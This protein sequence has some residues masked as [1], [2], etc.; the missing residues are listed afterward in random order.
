M[1]QQ[2]LFRSRL[3]TVRFRG[4][5]APAADMVVIVVCEQ[6]NR[7]V[8][9]SDVGAGGCFLAEVDRCDDVIS[10]E[11]A[12]PVVERLADTASSAVFGLA[13]GTVVVLVATGIRR[14]R[15]AA[16]AH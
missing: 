16:A 14:L 10:V 2:D 1:K 5:A 7:R 13:L 9:L 11:P 12:G 3:L 4:E 8:L 15:P 6:Q